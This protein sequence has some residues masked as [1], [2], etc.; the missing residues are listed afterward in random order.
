[1]RHKQAVTLQAMQRNAS[2]CQHARP[3]NPL[4]LDTLLRRL[5]ARQRRSQLQLLP[6]KPW[7]GLPLGHMRPGRPMRPWMGEEGPA[8]EP[9]VKCRNKKD[10][11][12][13]PHTRAVYLLQASTQSHLQVRHV[14]LQA[15]SV[16]CR[17]VPDACRCFRRGQ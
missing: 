1:M 14:C 4:T 12:E 16:C 9:C 3:C 15:C 11:P 6:P 17:L 2:S 5:S 10:T 7:Y 8:K 13:I